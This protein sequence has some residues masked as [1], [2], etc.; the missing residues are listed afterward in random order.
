MKI[1]FNYINLFPNGN[2]EEQCNLFAAKG[3]EDQRWAFNN[4]IKFLQ[5][6]KERVEKTEITGG[7]LR[8]F[9]KTIKLFCEMSDLSINWKKIT[10]GLSRGKRYANDRIPILAEPQNLATWQLWILIQKL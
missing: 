10:R 1:F 9:V 7:T 2:L 8:N 5:Y 6:Q 4:I 3:L